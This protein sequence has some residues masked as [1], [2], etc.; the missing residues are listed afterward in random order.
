MPARAGRK[1]GTP[2]RKCKQSVP[3]ETRSVQHSLDPSFST[4]IPCTSEGM[5]HSV[6]PISV[7]PQVASVPLVAVTMSSPI[8]VTTPN[9]GASSSG[10]ININSPT[11]SPSQLLPTYTS[12]TLRQQSQSLPNTSNSNP[13]ILKFKTSQ[14]RV[15]QAC[16]KDYQNDNDTMSLVVSRL[17][18]GLFQICLLEVS[19]YRKP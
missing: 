3:I 19:F 8:N 13:F 9:S 12:S 18:E 16:R 7:G 5:Y 14:V 15:C 1:S 4:D 11:V 10:V 6:P 17:R 2:N